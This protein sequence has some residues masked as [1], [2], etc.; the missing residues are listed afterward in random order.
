VYIDIVALKRQGT[1]IANIKTRSPAPC[2]QLRQVR[3]PVS[4]EQQTAS[5]AASIWRQSFTP[6]LLS[7]ENREMTGLLPQI[8]V[9]GKLAP[10]RYLNTCRYSLG[11][12]KKG[13]AR[14]PTLN[15]IRKEISTTE[16]TSRFPEKR[17]Q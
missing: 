2:I 9:F 8:S 1:V 3:V 15:P 5:T 6:L 11:Q 12:E 4:G 7:N 14:R 17:L 13:S 16:Q 10:I